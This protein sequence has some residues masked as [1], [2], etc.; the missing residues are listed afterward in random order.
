MKVE[1]SRKNL[2]QDLSKDGQNYRLEADDHSHTNSNSKGSHSHT[3]SEYSEPDG[4]VS[5]SVENQGHAP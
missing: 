3:N 5:K 4:D 1:S 2:K